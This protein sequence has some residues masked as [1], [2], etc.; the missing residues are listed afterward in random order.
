MKQFFSLRSISLWILPLVLVILYTL[1]RYGTLNPSLISWFNPFEGAY[2]VY[3][4]WFLV[5]LMIDISLY[6]KRK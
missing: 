1:F 3:I 6:V 4:G 2:L 5:G